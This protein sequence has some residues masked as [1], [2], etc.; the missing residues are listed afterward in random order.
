ML[1]K[2]FLDFF[3]RLRENK[4]AQ[5]CGSLSLLKIITGFFPGGLPLLR[6]SGPVGAS[7]GETQTGRDSRGVGM[8]RSEAAA[9]WPA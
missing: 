3:T 6:V 9:T 2:P 4:I 7:T 1:K 5:A 8:A